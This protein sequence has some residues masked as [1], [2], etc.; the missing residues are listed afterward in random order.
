MAGG[1]QTRNSKRNG[2]GGLVFSVN[3]IFKRLAKGRF[4]DRL[5]IGAAV[6][7]AATLEYL[8]VEIIDLA[9]INAEKDGQVI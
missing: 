7:L 3:L 5:G 4:S 2:K 1:I 6:F 9:G 8:T